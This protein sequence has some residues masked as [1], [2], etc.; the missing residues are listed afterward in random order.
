MLEVEVT[1]A[2]AKLA[3]NVMWRFA[4]KI[5]DKKHVLVKS[6]CP[7][8]QPSS[9]ATYICAILA[10]MKEEYGWR[11]TLDKDFGFKGGLAA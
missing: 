9:H 10:Y 11:Y 8:I 2:T 5:G 6:T 7:Y 4:L 3:N 1:P